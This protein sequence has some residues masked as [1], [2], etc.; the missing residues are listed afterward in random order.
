MASDLQRWLVGGDMNA[1]DVVNPDTVQPLQFE[2]TIDCCKR[3]AAAD[4]VLECEAGDVEVASQR[5]ANLSPIGPGAH[6]LSQS[7]FAVQHVEGPGHAAPGQLR[8]EQ[9]R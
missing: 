1:F 9:T 5:G 2:R 6:R 4:V 8:G 3:V 7:G